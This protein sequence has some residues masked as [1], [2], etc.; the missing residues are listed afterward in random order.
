MPYKKRKAVFDRFDGKCAYCGIKT[1]F[2]R[3]YMGHYWDVACVD[4]IKP[5]SRGGGDEDGNLQLLCWTCNARKY[6]S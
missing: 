2:F 6:N 4:H 5:V 1:R 3:G